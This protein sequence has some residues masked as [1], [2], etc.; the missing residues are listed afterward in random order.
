[1]E[2]T[3]TLSGFSVRLT[4]S[5]AMLLDHL[6]QQAG[7]AISC[8]EL[9]HAALGYYDVS[10]VEAQ[11]IIRPHIC[12][13]RKKIEPDSDSPRLILTVPYKCYLFSSS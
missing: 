11:N 4:S 7:T 12:R 2:E 8:L 10:D 5:E 1:M 9:A 13:M 6:M 3:D